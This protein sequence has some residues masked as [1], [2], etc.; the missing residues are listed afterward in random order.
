MIV[1]SL[2]RPAR[3]LPGPHLQTLWH[4]VAK[5][6]PRPATR[7]E[8]LEL[9]DGDFLD[10][11]WLSDAPGVPADAPLVC[12]FH[13]LAGSIDSP[14]ARSI[15]NALQAKGF[16]A[17]LMHFRG[18]G[19]TPNRLAR[20]YHSGDTGDVRFFVQQLRARGEV[21]PLLAVG[22]SL[23]A[24]VLVK[25]LGE[26]GEQSPFAAAVAVSPPLV[27]SNG[28][29]TLRR[30]F[31][32][33]YQTWLL[34]QLKATARDKANAGLLP[35]TVS[36]DKVLNAKDFW[37]FDSAFTAPLHG[38]RDAAHYFEA[39]SGKPFLQR[40][41]VPTLV[42]LSRDDPFYTADVLPTDAELSEHV[43]LELADHGGHVGFVGPGGKPW[44]D[45]R[46]P[47]WLTAHA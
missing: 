46:I 2:F 20:A 19:G 16:R 23:G 5:D 24:N 6:P 39:S 25:F 8:R 18:C 33:V 17:V 21:G 30:G 41:R 42:I 3:W 1:K 9:P 47:E 35:P 36:M 38:F 12:V 26:E 43:T 37:Q 32:R 13:G 14:Y 4:R 10:L 40:I 34:R 15:L 28:A 45:L 27:L 7:R 22:F 29:D 44:L 31:A 11:D